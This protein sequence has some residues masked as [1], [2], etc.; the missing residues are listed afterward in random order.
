[1][2]KNALSISYNNELKMLRIQSKIKVKDI[3]LKLKK[4]SAWVTKMEKGEIY[5]NEDLYNMIK[6]YYSSNIEIHIKDKK[7][8]EKIKFLMKENQ[9]L[10]ELLS[11]YMPYDEKDINR[12]IQSK[13]S[14]AI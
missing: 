1:M 3:A 12:I 9:K 13:E 7:Y 8:E 6:G 11:L 14:E 10:K 2:T 5:I 4:S